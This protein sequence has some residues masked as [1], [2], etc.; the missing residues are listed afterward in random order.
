MG[1]LLIFGTPTSVV[2][3]TIPA[4]WTG[5]GANQ[6]RC[7]WHCTQEA[8]AAVNAVGAEDAGTVVSSRAAIIAVAICTVFTCF[9]ATVS[10]RWTE[11]RPGRVDGDGRNHRAGGRHRTG[12]TVAAISAVV[13]IETDRIFSAWT[14]VVADAI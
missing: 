4:V 5:V 9:C 3:F 12:D 13:A 6:E 11:R 2:A 7:W 10:G 8:Y 1:A 14:S